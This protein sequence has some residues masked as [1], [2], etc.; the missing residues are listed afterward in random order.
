VKA[1]DIINFNKNKTIKPELE[2]LEDIS[3]IHE[4]SKS[5]DNS[6]SINDQ[7]IITKATPLD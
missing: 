4:D 2:A 1:E 7:F 5:F 3:S 6:F